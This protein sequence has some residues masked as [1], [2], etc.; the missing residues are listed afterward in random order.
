MVAHPKLSANDKKNCGIKF[1]KDLKCY[2][3]TNQPDAGKHFDVSINGREAEG[4][5]PWRA[6]R[7]AAASSNGC[8]LPLPLFNTPS[9]ASEKYATTRVLLQAY[10]TMSMVG[11]ARKACLQ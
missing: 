10:H 11:L 4:H 8:G 2:N 5:T 3:T 1:S 9:R 6:N 7:Q